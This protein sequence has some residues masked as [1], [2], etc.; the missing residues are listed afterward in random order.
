[1]KKLIL[2][3]F[4]LPLILISCNKEN[5]VEQNAIVFEKST[6]L[7][8]SITYDS[9]IPLW[10]GMWFVRPATGYVVIRFKGNEKLEVFMVD[11]YYRI[12]SETRNNGSY[13]LNYPRLSI[14]A[15][16]EKFETTIK[17]D[18]SILYF[19]LDDIRFTS[20]IDDFK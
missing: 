18:G 1:M 9:E 6:F 4:L 19:E 7:S 8:E 11:K 15:G 2:F 13:K 3:I 5:N 14:S 12:I 17:K 16:T 10:G 20:V